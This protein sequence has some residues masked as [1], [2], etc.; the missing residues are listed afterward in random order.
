MNLYKEI[1]ACRICGSTQLATIL[2]LGDQALTGVFPATAC[3]NE[4]RGPVTL[5]KCTGVDSC[6]LTQLKQSYSIDEMYGDNYGYRSS[7]NHSMVR[8]L[9]QKIATLRERINLSAQDIVMDIGSNDG[10]SLNFYPEYLQ[11]VGF[12][13]S[14]GKFKQYYQSGITL[15]EDF[16]DFAAYRDKFGDAKA[17][18]IT[19][20][21]M[22]YDLEDPVKFASDVYAC[23][24]DEGIWCFEQSY[25]VTMLQQN[26]YDT[27][28]QEHLS[29]Y[30][31]AVI[32]Y[33]LNK[34][35]MK[36]VDVELNDIN[37]GS[38]SVIAVKQQNPVTESAALADLRQSE[39]EFFSADKSPFIEFKQ[40]VQ[41]ITKELKAY[42]DDLVGSGKRVAALG[43]ST[44]GNVLLQY[45]GFDRA[46]IEYIGE[47]NPDKFGKF[48]PGTHIPIISEKQ[49]L[50][51]NFDAYLILPWHFKSFFINAASFSGKTLLFPMP[52][53]QIVEV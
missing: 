8:H 17:K 24:S 37:G 7:L 48:T 35:G 25:L 43:A 29:Y 3:E 14:A 16:F 41:N 39:A 2:E 45:C 12:D 32:E 10:T 36:A 4:T 18:I 31:L 21:A 19:S 51:A 6:G 40:N 50:D 52:Q 9:E 23:L 44:K 1:K 46:K 30:S 42:I 20:F 15:I 27:I 22:F 34:A 5:V 47:V 11:R 13:P 28:C 53:L 49:L 38:F 33:I 26:A